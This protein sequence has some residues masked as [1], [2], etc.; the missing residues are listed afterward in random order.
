MNIL[1]LLGSSR[2]G[3]HGEKVAKWI[4]KYVSRQPGITVDYADV[5]DLDLGYFDEAGPIGS[6]DGNYK[7]LKAKAWAKRVGKADGFIVVTPEY[8]H[9]F[10][11]S[12][13]D[14]IDYAWEEWHYKPVS[15]AGYSGGPWGGTR[16][17]EQLR[18]TMLGVKAFPLYD[19]TQIPFI[20]SAFDDNGKLLN[21]SAERSLES[22]TSELVKVIDM[23]SD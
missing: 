4:N 12:L 16:A 6:I 3:R 22:M 10:P 18:L 15:F 14:A 5:R 2:E 9:S 1:I 23:L 20:S 11:A 7:N 21:D 19:T 17:I 13:K 8:N